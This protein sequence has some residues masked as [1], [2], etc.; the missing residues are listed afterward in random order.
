KDISQGDNTIF[1]GAENAVFTYNLN[2]QELKTIS[3]INGLSGNS[4]STIHYSDDFDLLVIGY[5]NGLIE[6]VKK[7]DQNVLKVVD[8]VEKQ[9]I[10]PNKKRINNIREHNGQL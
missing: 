8:I 9:S 5:E 6:I 3:S 2:T 4:I 1:V 10:P 7:D